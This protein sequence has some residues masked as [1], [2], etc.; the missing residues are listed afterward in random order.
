M[1]YAKTVHKLREQIIKF[2]GELSF[3]W[4]K[5]MQRFIV[6]ALYGIQA[7]QSVRLTEIAR[8]LEEKIPLRKTHCRL[9]RQ[10][11]RWGLW[12]KI[13][14]SLCQMASSRV[15]E[16]TLLVLDISDIAKKYA[17]RMEYLATV[18]DGSEGTLTNGYWT[19]SVIGAEGGE[20][21]LT[22]LYT[23]LYSQAGPDFRSENAEVCKAISSVSEHTEKRGIWVL[24][25]GGDR[26][27][28]IHHLLG[29]KLRFIIR[30]K[31]D[32]H[33]VYRGNKRPVT[34]VNYFFPPHCLN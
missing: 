22:P 31:V 3:G 25:R 8:S 20:R 2:S 17:R 7:R 23:R 13:T 24:D 27:E 18:H 21:M 1:N 19:C 34:D 15:K 10:L 29:N 14:D 33:L 5:V 11:G 32:R 28:I 12:R 4:P 16:D 6:E 30:L 9:C 26:R